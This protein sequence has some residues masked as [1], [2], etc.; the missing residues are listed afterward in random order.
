VELNQK[1]DQHGYV[2]QP[3]IAIEV[4]D[5]LTLIDIMMYDHVMDPILT[6]IWPMIWTCEHYIV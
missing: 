1:D 4:Y 2:I 3:P 6:P 5:M